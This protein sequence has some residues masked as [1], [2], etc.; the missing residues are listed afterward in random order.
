MKKTALITGAGSGIGQATAIKL[1]QDGYSIIVVGRRQIALEE[2]VSKLAGG[3]H[4]MMSV[5]VGNKKDFSA[6]LKNTLS[7]KDNLVAV[8]ANAGIGGENKYGDEDRWESII[9]TNLSGP[10]YTIME[11][12]PF[13]EKS[14]SDFKH[15]LI[16]GSCLSRFGVPNYPAY[17]ASKSGV[18]GLA[19]ALA[20]DFASKK[21]LV[22]AILPGWVETDMAKQGIR[23]LAEADNKP[24]QD[25]FDEQMG[26]VPLNKMSQPEEIA[27]FVSYLFSGKQSSMTGQSIDINNGAFMI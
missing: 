3:D 27:G 12:L 11:C 10:Y 23:L 1:S 2:T 6:M 8:F 25:A 9:Q 7:V 18:N 15:V 19:K 26:Y 4:K 13:L 5:D 17:I 16:T 20:I 21:I 22:N 14:T 24:Y